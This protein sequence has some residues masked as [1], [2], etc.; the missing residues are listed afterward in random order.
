MMTSVIVFGAGA[1]KGSDTS[2]I[3]PLGKELFYALRKY[4]PTGWGKLPQSLSELFENDF[5]KGML[6]LSEE[7]P[8]WMPVLQRA[9]ASYFFGFSPSYTS[10]YRKLAR[11]LK[12][13]KWNGAFATLNYER[14]L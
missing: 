9:M 1:S 7:N 6:R 8:H 11:R 5:E 3:P 4:N 10:L 12:L 13:A 2:G 14:L